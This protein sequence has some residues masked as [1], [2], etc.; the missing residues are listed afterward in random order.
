MRANGDI[1]VPFLLLRVMKDFS[2]YREDIEAQR[3]QAYE[4]SLKQQEREKNKVAQANDQQRQKN[5]QKDAQRDTESAIDDV[6][7]DIVTKLKKRY[8]IDIS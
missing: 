5:D 7:D 1:R 3:Q 8:N 6:K 4:R 2:T